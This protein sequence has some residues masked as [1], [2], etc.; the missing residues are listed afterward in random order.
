[1]IRAA[2]STGCSAK[3]SV[4]MLEPRKIGMVGVSEPVLRNATARQGGVPRV[5]SNPA[6]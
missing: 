1:M 5:L 2:P 3:P 4:W 6:T